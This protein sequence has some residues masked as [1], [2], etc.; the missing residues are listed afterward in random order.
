[1]TIFTNGNKYC[2]VTSFDACAG[3]TAPVG[4][5]IR[6]GMEL[7]SESKTFLSRDYTDDFSVLNDNDIRSNSFFGVLTAQV[8]EG[9]LRSFTRRQSWEEMKMRSNKYYFWVTRRIS[10]AYQDSIIGKDGGINEN[11]KSRIVKAQCIFFARKLKN[12]EISLLTKIRILKTTVSMVLKRER[13]ERRRR[14]LRCF[15][16]KMKTNSFEYPFEWPCSEKKA[17]YKIGFYCAF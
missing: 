12:R 10:F 2:V 3:G 14:F 11:V 6:E 1:M 17:V 16:D 9:V 4:S 5:K 7:K 13:F 8:Q 15:T